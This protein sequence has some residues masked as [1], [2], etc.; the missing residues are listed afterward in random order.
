MAIKDCLF[1][2]MRSLC[3]YMGIFTTYGLGTVIL[4][5]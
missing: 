4:W 3:W 2:W 1:S 5:I